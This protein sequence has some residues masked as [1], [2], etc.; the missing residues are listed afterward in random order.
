MNLF[1]YSLTYPFIWLFSSL[2]MRVLH[3]VSDLLFMVVYYIVGYRKDVVKDNLK[4]AFPDKTDKEINKLAKKFF[5]HFIDIMIESVRTFS[6]TEK[7]ILKRYT[8]KN[9]ELINSLAKD[10][11]SI[12]LVGAHLA[13]WEWSVCMPLILDIDF[14][15]TYSKLANPYFDKKIKQNRTQFGAFAIKTSETV[16]TLHYNYSNKKTGLYLLLSDQS[17]LI[18]KTHYWRNFFGTKVPVHTGAETIAKK[19]DFAMVNCSTRR[20]KRGYYETE[21]SLITDSPKEFEDYQLTDKYFEITEKAISNQPECYLW[22]H[23]RFKHQHK[24]D[25]WLDITKNKRKKRKTKT[26]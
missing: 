12:V 3:G 19:Y 23:K 17:P 5:K 6:I 11:K 2:P 16:K 10:G 4:L 22:T 18:H 26:S 8:L 1:I 13:N 20:V 14:Y 9:P 24:F 25:E 15:A 21:F 7:E